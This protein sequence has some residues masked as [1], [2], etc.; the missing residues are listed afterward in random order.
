MT[1]IQ[2]LSSGLLY[3]R[4]GHL[5][6][7]RPAVGELIQYLFL[8]LVKEVVSG[9]EIQNLLVVNANCAGDDNFINDKNTNKR[10]KCK[11][12]AK[13]KQAL[14]QLAGFLSNSS[15]AGDVKL[16]KKRPQTDP[17]R[18][19]VSSPAESCAPEDTGTTSIKVKTVPASSKTKSRPAKVKPFL[20]NCVLS[21]AG[22][23]KLAVCGCKR[24]KQSVPKKTKASVVAAYPATMTKSSTTAP[25]V[26][27]S[28]LVVQRELL[29]D[30][31]KAS[32][33]QKRMAEEL[34]KNA[35][36]L[37]QREGILII[38]IYCSRI[39]NTR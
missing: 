8:N 13:Q 1:R 33:E 5:S 15:Y 36:A 27:L 24:G 11:V 3:R 34:S 10:T 26:D 7:F 29:E 39:T 16:S 12:T 9:S 25:A 35:K 32:L 30:I 23:S 38:T 17:E 28:A 37:K 6:G 18:E 20:D 2:L 19:S 4:E 31:K 22:S 14:K 21:P